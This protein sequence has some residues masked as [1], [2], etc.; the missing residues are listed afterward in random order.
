MQGK[1]LNTKEIFLSHK[2][3]ENTKYDIAYALLVIRFSNSDARLGISWQFKD[4]IWGALSQMNDKRSLYEALHVY[5]KIYGRGMAILRLQAN[6]M[7]IN[8]PKGNLD[9]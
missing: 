7:F 2:N 8:F 5:A 6:P 9:L 4:N 3:G 1:L